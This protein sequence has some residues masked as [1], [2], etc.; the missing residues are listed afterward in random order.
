MTRRTLFPAMTLVTAAALGGCGIPGES[1]TSSVYGEATARNMISQLAYANLEGRLI[2]LNDRFQAAATDTV[3]FAFD[4]SGLDASARAALDTQ[5]AWLKANPD[6]RM[7]V[8][9]HTDLVGSTGYN[10]RLGLRRAQSVVRYMVGKGIDRGRLIAAESRGEGDPVVV[11]E[12]RERRNRRAV[13]MVAGFTRGYVGDGLDGVYANR[14]YTTYRAT[15][16]LDVSEAVS[17]ETG[18]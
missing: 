3:N 15:G 11:T 7:T 13:T 17:T 14:I 12:E 9:G 18:G 8:V 10:A 1:I 6:V 4:R 16:G 2:A 5:I